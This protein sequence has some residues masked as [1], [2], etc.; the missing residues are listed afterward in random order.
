MLPFVNLYYTRIAADY[1]IFHSLQES[2]NPGYLERS[3]RRMRQQ[4][5]QTYWLSP[6]EHLHTF[7]R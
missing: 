7:G 1:L 2:V 5:G 3:E 4:T 6:S